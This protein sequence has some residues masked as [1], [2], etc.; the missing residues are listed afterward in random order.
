MY[1]Y[2]YM[3][4]FRFRVQLLSLLNTALKPES[5]S[6]HLAPSVIKLNGSVALRRCDMI[7]VDK[8]NPMPNE[9]D[10]DASLSACV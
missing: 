7:C 6:D 9:T 3:H 4:V 5:Q 2:L 10:P 1:N 8:T